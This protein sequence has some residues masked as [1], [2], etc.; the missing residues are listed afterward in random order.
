MG[1]SNDKM[2][3]RGSYRAHL[4]QARIFNMLLW[5]GLQ[6]CLAGTPY[7]GLRSA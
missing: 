6:Y 5:A 3:D 4:L 1:V 7:P 2:H